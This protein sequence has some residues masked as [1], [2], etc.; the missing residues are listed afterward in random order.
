M[1]NLFLSSISA[2][3]Q[4]GMSDSLRAWHFTQGAAFM[5][6]TFG[7]FRELLMRSGVT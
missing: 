6:T 4:G 7:S 5:Q 1:G 2:A 3:H